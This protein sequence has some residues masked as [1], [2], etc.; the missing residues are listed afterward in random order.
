ML[1][2]KITIG[3]F[4][5]K[6]EP[7]DEVIVVDNRKCTGMISY[8]RGIIKVSTEG[9]RSEQL[10][11]RTLWHEIVHGIIHYRNFDPTKADL[12]TTVEELATGL[13]LLCKQNGLLPGQKGR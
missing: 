5:Y 4:D 10:Q 9:D 2:E 7:T 8:E 12:E 11:E 1:P 6:I 13:Y 3:C